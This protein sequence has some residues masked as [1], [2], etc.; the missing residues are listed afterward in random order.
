MSCY[1][2]NGNSSPGD[3]PCSSGFA[4]ACCPSGWN[5]ESNGLCSLAAQG[6]YG[7][8]TC[9]D[10]TWGSDNCPQICT[11]SKCFSFGRRQ[12]GQDPGLTGRQVKL[13]LGMRPCS[14]A[15]PEAIAA[16][17]IARMIKTKTLQNLV[18]AILQPADSHLLLCL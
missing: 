15:A 4:S 5:C 16:M 8:Y 11:H 6:F 1:Y 17:R 13:L 18:A 3:I 7:R 10:K 14:N 12:S 2:P 9:T